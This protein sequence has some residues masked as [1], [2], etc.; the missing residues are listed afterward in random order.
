MNKNSPRSAAH[1]LWALALTAVFILGA[2]AAVMSVT[3]VIAKRAA[4][5]DDLAP[6]PA[7]EVRTLT[8]EQAYSYTVE[9]QFFGQ[10]EA[11][12]TATVSFE[13]VGNIIDIPVEEGDRVDKGDVLAR[14]DTRVLEANQQRLDASRQAIEARVEL[15]RLTTDRQN[16][17]R[18]RGFAS[19]QALDQARLE[20]A[21]LNARLAET[22]A[23]LAQIAVEL[24]QSVLTAPFDAR[25]ASRSLDEGM[26]AS[27]QQT[28]LT[29]LEQ[30]KP[31]LRVGID[32]ELIDSITLADTL[33]ATIAGQSRKATVKAL[34]PD[35]DA[36][37]KTRTLL[38][39]LDDT[40]AVIGETGYVTLQQRIE[41]TGLRVPTA[42]L[43]EGVRGLWTVMT[44]IDGQDGQQ[45]VAVEAVEIIHADDDWAYVRGTLPPG[46]RVIAV[47][48]HRV[49]PG[50]VVR[51][52]D[53]TS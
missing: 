42:A 41:E 46:S 49:V 53:A 25:V 43:Q 2:G 36:R 20:L 38:L 27:P 6:A 11:G 28:L 3:S 47:G 31:V 22:R 10:V 12:R 21:E 48:P 51:I 23:S 37:S 7:Q 52:R 14:L 9:R 30:T 39:T 26:T 35:L 33:E 32:P 5:S 19:E 1:R 4:Q 17:L 18:N 45:Q 50:Q 24:D 40:Q 13:R 44:V 8:V 34:R 16:N 15:A 29:L